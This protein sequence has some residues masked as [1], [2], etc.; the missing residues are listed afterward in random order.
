MLIGI[1]MTIIFL[2]LLPLFLRWVG[3]LQYQAF[4]APSIFARVGEI[5]TYLLGI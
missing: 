5:L 4:T 1:V 2:I 3:V